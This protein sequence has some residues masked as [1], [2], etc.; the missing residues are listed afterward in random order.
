M[1]SHKIRRKRKHS[2]RTHKERNNNTK[3]KHRRKNKT[4]KNRLK[5]KSSG[6]GKLSWEQDEQKRRSNFEYTDDNEQKYSFNNNEKLNKWLMNKL[7]TDSVEL[8][9]GNISLSNIDDRQFFERDLGDY[10]QSGSLSSSGTF[11]QTA[12]QT[13]MSNDASDV[14]MLGTN[15][16]VTNPTRTE[17]VNYVKTISEKTENIMKDDYY[18]VTI[19]G[20]D[21]PFIK[22]MDK[23]AN[24]DESRTYPN[25]LTNRELILLE[26][27]VDII[28][29]V[30]AEGNLCYDGFLSIDLIVKSY[31]ALY[32]YEE[33]EGWRLLNLEPK[34][35]LWIDEDQGFDEDTSNRTKFKAWY[36]NS[37]TNK[38]AQTF[39]VEMERHF[40]NFLYKKIKN[41]YLMNPIY[42]SD[43]VTA[44]ILTDWQHANTTNRVVDV[45]PYGGGSIRSGIKLWEYLL[46]RGN[47]FLDLQLDYSWVEES[48]QIPPQEEITKYNIDL[49]YF[50]NFEENNHK[51][52]T[53]DYPNAMTR[54]KVEHEIQKATHVELYYL[55]YAYT[56]F[57]DI[58][59][60]AKS[61][62]QKFAEKEAI[63]NNYEHLFITRKGGKKYDYSESLIHPLHINFTDATSKAS[64]AVPKLYELMKLRGD[65]Y[66]VHTDR[67]PFESR[68]I[69][70]VCDMATG[71][72]GPPVPLGDRKPIYN[73][74]HFDS[75]N[76]KNHVYDDALLYP[77]EVHQRNDV[78]EEYID[79]VIRQEVEDDPQI[80]NNIDFLTDFNKIYSCLLND[81]RVLYKEY[82]ATSYKLSS[83][84]I[85]D[86]EI[87]K[88]LQ[89]EISTK[90]LVK[91]KFFHLMN[92]LLFIS[93]TE[94]KKSIEEFDKLKVLEEFLTK[95]TDKSIM[96][97]KDDLANTLL[98]KETEKAM[99]SSYLDDFFSGSQKENY[100]LSDHWKMWDDGSKSRFYL[101][102]TSTEDQNKSLLPKQANERNESRIEAT[103]I[104]R[105]SPFFRASNVNLQREIIPDLAEKVP[106][107]KT[108]GTFIKGTTVKQKAG[109]IFFNKAF[110]VNNSAI[111]K[112]YFST[113][114]DFNNL[115]KQIDI[116]NGWRRSNFTD[117]NCKAE[118]SRQLNDNDFPE[119]ITKLK[120]V[121]LKIK[122]RK[123]AEQKKSDGDGSVAME[124]DDSALEDMFVKPEDG[125]I[126]YKKNENYINLTDGEANFNFV[127]VIILPG[128][129]K[130]KYSVRLELIVPLE[131]NKYKKVTPFL[132]TQKVGSRGQT[133]QEKF[134]TGDRNT[135]IENMKKYFLKCESFVPTYNLM[136]PIPYLPL[137]LKFIYN[138]LK[139]GENSKDGM[140]EDFSPLGYRSGKLSD[141]SPEGN[142]K[143]EE[144]EISKG[145]VVADDDEASRI[146]AQKAEIAEAL[147][148]MVTKV[149][150]KSLND[151]ECYKFW[152]T[153]GTE[154]DDEIKT[155]INYV[156]NQIPNV[157]KLLYNCM[158]FDF[159]T[160]EFKALGV[161]FTGSRTTGRLRSAAFSKVKQGKTFIQKS[162]DYAVGNF[163]SIRDKVKGK[164]TITYRPLKKEGENE[165]SNGEEITFS[166]NNPSVTGVLSNVRQYIVYCLLTNEKL[167]QNLANKLKKH[168]EFFDLENRKDT[169]P[170]VIQ[171]LID[172]LLRDFIEMS[173]RTMTGGMPKATKKNRG[174]RAAANNPYPPHTGATKKH[175]LPSPRTRKHLSTNPPLKVIGKSIKVN[176]KSK[177]KTKAKTKANP[178]AKTKAKAKTK[179]S[180]SS[181]PVAA[182]AA[183][184][185][186]EPEFCD[187]NDEDILQLIDAPIKELKCNNRF[188][189]V[190]LLLNHK[191]QG[192]EMQLHQEKA[193]K[194]LFTLDC[195]GM[196][197]LYH[198]YSYDGVMGIK[199]LRKGVSLLFQSGKG[200]QISLE[201]NTAG[202]P[203][204]QRLNKYDQ[205]PLVNAQTGSEDD[206]TEDEDSGV[207]DLVVKNPSTSSASPLLEIKDFTSKNFSILYDD[208]SITSDENQTETQLAINSVY[209]DLIN[210]YKRAISCYRNILY[211]VENKSANPIIKNQNYGKLN[212]MFSEI[213]GVIGMASRQSV[214]DLLQEENEKPKYLPEGVP[215]AT[216]IPSILR[217]AYQLNVF[218]FYSINNDIDINELI[219]DR[220]YLQK[221]FKLF[222]ENLP[223]NTSM[224]ERNYRFQNKFFEKNNKFEEIFKNINALFKLMTKKSTREKKKVWLIYIKILLK[225]IIITITNPKDVKNLIDNYI[226]EQSNQGD[227]VPSSPNSNSEGTSNNNS[228]KTPAIVR[229]RSSGDTSEGDSPPRVRSSSRSADELGEEFAELDFGEFLKFRLGKIRDTA[230]YLS[231][232]AYEED[233]VYSILESSISLPAKLK[234]N[235]KVR[236]ELQEQ[237]TSVQN[238]EMVQVLVNRGKET[239]KEIDELVN[240]LPDE[241]SLKQENANLQTRLLQMERE[242]KTAKQE[243]EMLKDNVRQHVPAE[244]RPPGFQSAVKRPRDSSDSSD[245]SNEL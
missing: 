174:P 34:I 231:S 109:K 211:K 17:V 20:A 153:F 154:T 112:E 157:F 141:Y 36:D 92:Y 227:A 35:K 152:S 239:F 198:V 93:K 150:Q 21:N 46:G 120:G 108:D 119:D 232:V 237:K 97:R 104:V 216:T 47:S 84:D 45:A 136:Q 151:N 176:P 166:T 215:P 64:S 214:A 121:C 194:R 81:V 107:K 123:K 44:E 148:E 131:N 11:A 41:K 98:G 87:E 19:E 171:E 100:H 169:E 85:G 82:I 226:P 14:V 70:Q 128:S 23:Q 5:F 66:P 80:K 217:Q 193:F 187:P 240:R 163:I 15:P 140:N 7:N 223:R 30:V 115:D 172:E 1:V 3:K 65:L 204:Y 205:D 218:S 129:T 161:N 203:A 61:T 37:Q 181:I 192:D 238:S 31:T 71:R 236:E 142:E 111:M 32:G 73:K 167:K 225:Y 219:E 39:G 95:G 53:K 133:L 158:L 110:K 78:Q 16:T 101:D 196:E 33:E 206:A 143:E 96:G 210:T 69:G 90:D 75:Y 208:L 77:L 170:I 67:L 147:N 13:P 49:I 145:E 202:D 220:I 10:T 18:I 185:T 117:C 9:S 48:I 4:R 102:F 68:G 134:L 26:N 62:R 60:S 160:A 144:Q 58:N 179:G 146:A 184:K 139:R 124:I 83:T 209:D 38:K 183:S 207:I 173:Q 103:N 59:N 235:K 245:S 229:T 221:T 189:T 135:I 89:N 243:I 122:P 155:K 177:A 186:Q 55:F 22:V 42:T 244:K 222:I 114:F 105:R 195:N 190:G 86:R 118:K 27:M 242:L 149:E 79:L 191:T 199:A 2:R 241:L 137:D 228:V 212:A 52:K 126:L 56:F 156:K 50:T 29:D 6:G 200:I 116:Y 51:A 91:L 72:V 162:I 63:L 74:S 127:R 54:E 230:N 132:Y 197:V 25:Y 178:K 180:P 224:I 188:A 99:K 213:D 12:A 76:G 165:V 159:E 28:H 125:S 168:K 138:F 24:L 201:A 106:K 234:K 40:K 164:Q 57:R 43:G 233:Q 182:N 88:V 175:L 94:C 113:N 130:T 8:D